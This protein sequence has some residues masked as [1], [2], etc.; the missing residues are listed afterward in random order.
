METQ[1]V[2]FT[3]KVKETDNNKGLETSMIDPLGKFAVTVYSTKASIWDTETGKVKK[4]FTV[5][6]QNNGKALA[7]SNDGKY[8]ALGVSG[9]EEVK[10]L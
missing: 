6:D 7:I 10:N 8:M 9:S 4:E 5:V 1:T 2:L 3:D